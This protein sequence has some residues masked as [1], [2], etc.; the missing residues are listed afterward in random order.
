[1]TTYAPNLTE[2]LD[3]EPLPASGIESGD[4]DYEA[5]GVAY[6]GYLAHP[7]GEGRHRGSWSCTTGS[8]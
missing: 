5:D 4:V 6:R 1:M 2:I 7:A 8:V 3:R